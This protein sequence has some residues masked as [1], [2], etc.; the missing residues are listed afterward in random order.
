MCP[1]GK[2]VL[3]GRK[4]RG[5]REGQRGDHGAR[6]AVHVGGCGVSAVAGKA[7]GE[8]SGLDAARTIRALLLPRRARLTFRGARLTTLPNSHFTV[9][10]SSSRKQKKL[11]K[12]GDSRSVEG[13]WKMSEP[14]TGVCV[15]MSPFRA[16]S[17]SG[18]RLSSFKMASLAPSAAEGGRGEDGERRVS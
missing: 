4:E 5:R 11:F 17:C 3:R 14:T 13:T 10:L 2:T 12:S 15:H 9:E 1:T 8:Q 18:V 16:A 6:A 7:G